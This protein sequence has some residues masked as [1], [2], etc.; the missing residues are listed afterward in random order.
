MLFVSFGALPR[1]ASHPDVALVMIITMHAFM[2]VFVILLWR[3]AYEQAIGLVERIKFLRRF[4]RQLHELRPAFVTLCKPR[5]FVRIAAFQAMAAVL[6]FL[7]FYL[8]LRSI[9]QNIGYM[10]SVFVLGVSYTFGAISF[11]PLGIGAFE[12]LI[13]VIML[14]LGIPAAI[15]AA[16]GLIYRGFNDV[17]MALLGAPALLYIRGKQRA[18]T[19]RPAA[20]AAAAERRAV[21]AAASD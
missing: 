7:L 5:T 18:G 2:S 8:A 17:L 15:G 14:T 11:L 19:W 12:G 16:S 1:L 3:A 20:T 6:S 10:N 4:D 21:T 13:T 9:H